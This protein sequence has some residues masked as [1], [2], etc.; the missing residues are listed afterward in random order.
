MGYKD[1]FNKAF[2]EGPDENKT[3]EEELEE[4]PELE[5]E[6]EKTLIEEEEVIPSVEVKQVVEA[7]VKPKTKK[8][9]QSSD[10]PAKDLM[11]EGIPESNYAEVPT[12]STFGV[13]NYDIDD[14]L[15]DF[16]KKNQRRGGIPITK[17]HL[18]ELVMDV[19]IYDMGLTPSGFNSKEEVREYLQKRLK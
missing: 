7:P 9:T 4:S 17:S 16:S 13:H 12:R 8:K 15:T 3:K 2:H 1:L 14:F 19:A 10:H 5:E 11:R 18:I 6:P